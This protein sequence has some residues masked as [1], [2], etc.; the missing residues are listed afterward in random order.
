MIVLVASTLVLQIVYGVEFTCDPPCGMNKHC[1]YGPSPSICVCDDF[2]VGEN[3]DIAQCSDCNGDHQ[4]CVGPNQCQCQDKWGPYPACNIPDCSSS[5]CPSNSHCAYPDVCKCN[6]GWAGANCDKHVCQN[7][8]GANQDCIGPN[9]CICKASYTGFPQCQTPLC[10]DPSCNDHQECASPNNCVCKNGWGGT[11]CDIPVCDDCT[12][13]NQR[14]V[15]AHDCQCQVG[16][17]NYP[18][19]DTPICSTP[20]TGNSE[21]SA[22]DTCKCKDGWAGPLCNVAMCTEPECNTNQMCDT[23]NN[24]VCKPGFTGDECQNDINECTEGSYTCNPPTPVCYNTHG[25]YGCVAG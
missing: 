16:W 9:D 25:A 20:C 23:P 2:W 4:R 21:C 10:T 14:C 12:G 3:C 18:E 6:S 11:L 7:C 17:S 1:K 24:C 15:S 8:S 22:P 13:S 19:C 5:S